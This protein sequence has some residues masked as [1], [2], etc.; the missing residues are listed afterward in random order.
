MNSSI[1]QTTPEEYDNFTKENL[2]AAENSRQR[3][4]NVRATLD[5]NYS[6]SLKD[7]RTQSNQVNSALAEKIA[8]TEQVFEHLEKELLK[9]GS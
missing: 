5:V 3:S 6:N 2:A 8:L 9:V 4:I 7:L 1:S